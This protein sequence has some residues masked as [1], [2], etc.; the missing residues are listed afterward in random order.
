M[1]IFTVSSKMC[2]DGPAWKVVD[3]SSVT[4]ILIPA[5]TEE[6][7]KCIQDRVLFWVI[8]LGILIKGDMKSCVSSEGGV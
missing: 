2:M 7:L 6:L 1:T 4:N 5:L 3:L 8:F